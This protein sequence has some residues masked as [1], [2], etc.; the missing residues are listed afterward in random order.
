[1][2]TNEAGQIAIKRL[3][4][5][6]RLVQVSGG[7]DYMFVSRNNITLAWVDPADVPKILGLR[8]GCCG[9]KKKPAFT[10][11]LEHDVPRW[12]GERSR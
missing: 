8:D 5:I 1:M 12:T 6:P 2:I 11:A 7:G 4:N 9:G 10:Y 3:K